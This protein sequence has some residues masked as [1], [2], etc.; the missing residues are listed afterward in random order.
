MLRINKLKD[1]MHG[2]TRIDTE[3]G[4]QWKILSSDSRALLVV[5]FYQ[6]MSKRLVN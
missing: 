1:I 3:E 5:N 2:E 4:N 6:E